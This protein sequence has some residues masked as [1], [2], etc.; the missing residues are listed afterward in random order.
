MLTSPSLYYE[1]KKNIENKDPPTNPKPLFVL[2]TLQ[3]Q[4]INI[5]HIQ[6]PEKQQQNI[7]TWSCLLMVLLSQ[8]GPVVT[9]KHQ[10]QLLS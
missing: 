5:T 3:P 8:L 10:P 7:G 9:Q 1:V 4:V 6:L 2:Y